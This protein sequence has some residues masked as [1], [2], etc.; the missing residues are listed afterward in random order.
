MRELCF[1]V[2]VCFATVVL[3]RR[4][5]MAL[6]HH[7]SPAVLA[8]LGGEGFAVGTIVNMAMCVV[9]I[10]MPTP[11]SA[12][13]WIGMIAILCGLNASVGLIVVGVLVYSRW[14]QASWWAMRDY[15]EDHEV[16]NRP[17]ETIEEYRAAALRRT[18]SDD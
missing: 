14:R 11:D 10:V 16:R 7:A 6:R 3:A 15:V 2:V 5:R 1:Y 9:L 12:Q 18:L 17:P 4:A 8:R 13:L